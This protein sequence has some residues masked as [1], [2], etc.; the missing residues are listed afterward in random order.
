MNIDLT[1]ISILVTPI[2]LGTLFS[3]ICGIDKT[4]GNNVN[5]RPDP[6]VFGIVWP[7]LY[8]LLGLS[9]NYARNTVIKTGD[10]S[11]DILYIL[12]N[13]LLC[14]WIYIYS[15]KGLKKE[16]VYILILCIIAGLSCF[17]V[18]NIISKLLITPLLGWLYLATLINVFEVE[19]T[20]SNSI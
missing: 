10:I 4:S 9:W 18:G 12:L 11:P 19:K 1:F 16:G 3:F 13:T 17:T 8:L 6:V 2:V 5:I 14:M 7:I 15:C 20:N